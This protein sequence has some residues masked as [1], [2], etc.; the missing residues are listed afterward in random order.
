MDWTCLEDRYLCLNMIGF[1]TS[2]GEEAVNRLPFDM[3]R[4][5]YLGASVSLRSGTMVV[6]VVVAVML[7]DSFLYLSLHISSAFHGV[8]YGDR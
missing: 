8:P 3:G 5:G 6:C 1:C 2:C 7:P 4:I